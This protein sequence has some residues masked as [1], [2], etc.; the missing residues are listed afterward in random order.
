MSCHVFK[1]KGL[2]ACFHVYVLISLLMLMLLDHKV[3]DLFVYP[4]YAQCQ[5]MADKNGEIFMFCL[6]LRFY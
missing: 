3:V 2:L 4:I 1:S 5:M 6:S